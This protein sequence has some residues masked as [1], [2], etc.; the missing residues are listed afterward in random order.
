VDINSG[1]AALIVAFILF[2]IVMIKLEF[3]KA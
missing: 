2:V 1:A 3:D